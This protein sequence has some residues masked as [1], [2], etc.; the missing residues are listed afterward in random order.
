[1]QCKKDGC[2]KCVHYCT[3]CGYDESLHPMSEGYCSDKCLEEDNGASYEE[4]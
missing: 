3:S 1:M 2:D 4:D